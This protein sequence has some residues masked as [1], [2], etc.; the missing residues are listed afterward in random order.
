MNRSMKKIIILI[1]LLNTSYNTHSFE[2]TFFVRQATPEDVEALL[3]IDEEV[4]KIDFV[5]VFKEGYSD[6]EIGKNAEAIIS[7]MMEYDHKH[8]PEILNDQIKRFVYLAFDKT[9]HEPLGFLDAEQTDEKTIKLEMFCIRA[10]ARGIGVGK[11]LVD[12]LIKS[13]PCIK[14]LEVYPYK[15]ANENALAFYRKIGFVE[16]PIE[17]FLDYHNVPSTELY[18]YMKKEINE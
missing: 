12:Y 13:H 8:Y 2:K 18:V 4:S 10:K 1:A 3:K 11:A 5:R 14:I 15:K 9:T 6:Y 17:T 7:E 16:G